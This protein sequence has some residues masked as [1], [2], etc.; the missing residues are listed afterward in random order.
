MNKILNVIKVKMRHKGLVCLTEYHRL[1][2]M[3]GQTAKNRTTYRVMSLSIN[4]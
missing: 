3:C 1:P 4:C 2:Q